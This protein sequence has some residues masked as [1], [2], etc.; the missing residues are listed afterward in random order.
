MDGSTSMAATSESP[1]AYTVTCPICWKG[2]SLEVIRIPNPAMVVNADPASAPP[3][4]RHVERRASSRLSMRT[5]S[6]PNW[7]AM[8]MV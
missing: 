2:T 7:R 4:W 6:S 8:W 1:T 5:R 3:V